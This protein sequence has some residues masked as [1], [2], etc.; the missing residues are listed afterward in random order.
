MHRKGAYWPCKLKALSFRKRNGH[1][2]ANVAL[3]CPDARLWFRSADPQ[4]SVSER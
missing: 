4:I 2:G 3:G 1:G